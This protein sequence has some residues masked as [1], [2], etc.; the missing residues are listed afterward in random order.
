MDAAAVKMC[1]RASAEHLGTPIFL[2]QMHHCDG[3]ENNELEAIM[4]V[5]YFSKPAVALSAIFLFS[6]FS[7]CDFE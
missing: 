6:M 4:W 3:I 5:N 7:M 1:V 2:W